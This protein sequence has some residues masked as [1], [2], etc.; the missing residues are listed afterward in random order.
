MFSA[1]TI[2]VDESDESDN[3]NTDIDPSTESD[4]E[5]KGDNDLRYYFGSV[6]LE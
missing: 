5:D 6:S 1:L 3:Q 4:N 2:E